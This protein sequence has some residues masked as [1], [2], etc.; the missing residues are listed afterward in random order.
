MSRIFP[1]LVLGLI[2]AELASLIV[3]GRDIGLLATLLLILADGAIGVTI[4][5]WAGLGLAA[6]M[7][8]AGTDMRFATRQAASAF[9]MALAGVLFF[10]PGFVSDVVAIL[11]LIPFL[12]SLLADRLSAKAQVSDQPRAPG[13]WREGPIIEGEAHEI[14]EK[15]RLP[16]GDGDDDSKSDDAANR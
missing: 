5:R 10:V 1:L 9:L 15:R 8:K 14:D 6:T 11:L 13:S 16:A 7:R 12:R 3:M 2:V 4:I